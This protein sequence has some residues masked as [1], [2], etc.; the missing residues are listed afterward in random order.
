MLY[1]SIL[2]RVYSILIK[3]FQIFCSSDF[4][5]CCFTAFTKTIFTCGYWIFFASYIL[6]AHIKSTMAFQH[7][8]QEK[9]KFIVSHLISPYLI[10]LHCTVLPCITSK[11]N[12]LY[13]I[14]SYHSISYHITS[15]PTYF[16]LLYCI[17]LSIMHHVASYCI[18]SYYIVSYCIISHCTVSH[19]DL[20]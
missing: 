6:T 10:A 4:E 11:P 8:P 3:T 14:L 9:I 2:K 7:W 15:H 13:H 16:I 19:L 5:Q 12:E 17:I 20:F 1:L 18:L